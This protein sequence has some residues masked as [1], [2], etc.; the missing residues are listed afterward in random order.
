MVRDTLANWRQNMGAIVRLIGSLHF[1]RELGNWARYP[2]YC[3]VGSV[4]IDL[5]RALRVPDF[6]KLVQTLVRDTQLVIR[7]RQIRG[8]DSVRSFGATVLET[9][10]P[11][12]SQAQ[13]KR[14]LLAF[15][16]GDLPLVS[17]AVE[18]RSRLQ[19]Q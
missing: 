6:Q 2:I 14:G 4:R 8:K 15:Q 12:S 19:G 11:V 18:L 3:V 5:S 1:R 13:G 10:R 16:N 9:P 17:G 7:S